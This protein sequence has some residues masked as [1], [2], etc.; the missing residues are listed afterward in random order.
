MRHFFEAVDA[1]QYNVE[2]MITAA[3]LLGVIE[4]YFRYRM[5]RMQRG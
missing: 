1:G 2:L 4:L 5:K 3:L